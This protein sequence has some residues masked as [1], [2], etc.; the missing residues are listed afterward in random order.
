M[1]R[2]AQDGAQNLNGSRVGQIAHGGCGCAPGLVVTWILD[3]PS[4]RLEHVGSARVGE[5]A[6]GLDVASERLTL[7]GIHGRRSGRDGRNRSGRRR[8]NAHRHGFFNDPR[9]R[10]GR[11]QAGHLCDAAIETFERSAL[12]N[13]AALL[14]GQRDN[15]E[16]RRIEAGVT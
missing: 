14:Q 16:A 7:E 10:L 12:G 5:L 6:N 1:A 4:Q 13:D 11:I 15:G 3:N 8:P 9:I 2:S